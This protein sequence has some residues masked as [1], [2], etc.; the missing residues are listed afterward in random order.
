MLNY[1]SRWN[2]YSAYALSE[3]G[4]M[5]FCCD[6]DSKGSE[7]E[8]RRQNDR[9][10]RK[11]TKT[12]IANSYFFNLLFIWRNL[13]NVFAVVTR[14]TF[15]TSRAALPNGNSNV[16][17]PKMNGM[18]GSG[19][20]LPNYFVYLMHSFFKPQMVIIQT[21]FHFV[22]NKFDVHLEP[23]VNVCVPL[24]REMLLMVIMRERKGKRQVGDACWHN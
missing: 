11:I 22:A 23:I 16:D 5:V 1:D 2:A 10:K 9:K 12:P 4:R 21:A 17:C 18:T 19:L 6:I 3:F 20:G 13:L 8:W 14:Y 7:E 24:E 15:P